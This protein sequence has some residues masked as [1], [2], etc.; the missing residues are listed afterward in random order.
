MSRWKRI[1]ASGVLGAAT[2]LTPVGAAFA[3]DKPADAAGARV[4]SDFLSAYLGKSALPTLKITP[5]GSSYLVS[6]DFAAMTQALKAA[7]I[8]YDPAVLQFKVAEQDGG[9]WRVEVDK[10]PPISG[11]VT[12]PA[13][14]PGGKVN[15]QVEAT[16]LTQSALIDPKLN[17]IAS[18]HGAADKLTVVQRGTGVDEFIELGGLKFDG[19]TKSG[20]SGLVTTVAETLNSLNF[21]MDVDPKKADPATRGP[22]KPVHVSAQGG[23][24]SADVSLADFQPGPLLDAWRFSVAHPTRADYARD[25]EAL[26]PILT[27]LAADH[28]TASDSLKLDK[29][30]VMTEV[31]PVAIE[32]AALGVAI[33]NKGAESG[34]SEH[35]AVRAIKLP[36]GLAPPLYAPVIPTSFDIGFKAHG[37]DIEG[38]VQE[39]LADVKLDGDEP[40]LSETDRAKVS[41]K[42][43]G[44]RPIV[45]DIQPSHIEGP[46]LDLAFSGQVTI[47]QS[48]PVGAITIKLRDFDKTAKA[49]QGLGADEAQK[50]T[51]VLAMAKGLGKSTADGTM[52]WVCS[53]GADHVMKVNGLPLGK[54]PF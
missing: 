52:V 17:W 26:K 22:G 28:L 3:A 38:A 20:A 5:S 12:P 50:L 39:W 2:A 18:T 37:F 13:G 16:H 35:L 11:S 1:L 41:A 30:D 36:E 44:S 34:F 54:S 25:F 4:I 51:A 42:F 46:S 48:K 53:L 40:P 9:D 45:I 31:G 27:A 47:D 21:V 19:S 43:V 7:G 32:G 6:L 14:Q 8:V 49:V 24:G 29:L 15:V 23:P 10:I 33:V